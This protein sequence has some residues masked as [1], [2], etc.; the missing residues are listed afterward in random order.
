MKEPRDLSLGD[1]VKFGAEVKRGEET[2]PACEFLVV[3]KFVP[4]K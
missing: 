3:Y 2:F 1:V 4:Y